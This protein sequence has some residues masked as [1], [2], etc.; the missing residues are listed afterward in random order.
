M[1]Q[2]SLSELGAVWNAAPELVHQRNGQWDCLQATT[3]D[4]S[5]VHKCE[6]RYYLKEPERDCQRAPEDNAG[7]IAL[8]L[9]EEEWKMVKGKSRKAAALNRKDTGGNIEIDPRCKKDTGGMND[10]G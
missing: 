10:P 7:C 6:E 1:K 9:G 5:E 2:L 8:S 3:E 4:A